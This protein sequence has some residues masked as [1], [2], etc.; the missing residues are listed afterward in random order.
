MMPRGSR[1]DAAGAL[2]HVMGRGIERREIFLA[3]ADYQHFLEQMGRV[4]TQ[5]GA[6]CVAWSLMPNHNRARKPRALA[7][8]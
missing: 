8:G 3:V 2:H 4:L 5:G 7:R 6:R 1:V